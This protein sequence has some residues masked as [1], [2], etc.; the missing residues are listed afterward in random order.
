MPLWLWFILIVVLSVTTVIT[1]IALIPADLDKA[2]ND[3]IAA[4]E[5][6]DTAR[7]DRSIAV[8]KRHNASPGRQAVLKG[9]RTM[10]DRK[11]KIRKR[12]K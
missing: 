12:Q 7:L 10:A 4:H 8:L 11:G 9:L 2:Y 1:V 3:G 6:S 5:T